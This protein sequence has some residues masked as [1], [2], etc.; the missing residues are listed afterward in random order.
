MESSSRGPI[1]GTILATACS[2]WEKP[3]KSSV[4]IAGLWAVILTR[5]F[6]NT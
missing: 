2:D 1:E 3:Q 4:R 5:D 6:L